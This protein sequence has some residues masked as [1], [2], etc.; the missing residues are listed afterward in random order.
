[1]ARRKR[2]GGARK[3]GK[4][5]KKGA[6]LATRFHPL[7]MANP[8]SAAK[9][10]GIIKRDPLVKNKMVNFLK[11]KAPQLLTGG[12]LRSPQKLAAATTLAFKNVVAEKHGMTIGDLESLPIED[13]MDLEADVMEDM[14]IDFQTNGE[15]DEEN[16]LDPATIGAALAGGKKILGKIK[17]KRL[18]KGKGWFGKKAG[19]GGGGDTV[20]DA[21]K[22]A[23]KEFVQDVKQSEKKKEL[24]KALPW[25]IGG[26]IVVIGG[27]ILVMRSGKK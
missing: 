25:I 5:L 24:M 21:S 7:A 13:Q 11:D 3:L 12:V 14:D 4:V 20:A 9:A 15:D 1:M 23:A 18:A 19:D 10:I 8:V 22:Q 2:G 27:V 6:E 17:E 26:V 16:F